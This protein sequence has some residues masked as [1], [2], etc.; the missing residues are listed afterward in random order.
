MQR[1]LAGILVGARWGVAGLVVAGSSWLALDTIFQLPQ[2][3]NVPFDLWYGNWLAVVVITG[4]FTV[5]LVGLL[6]PRR[7]A[8]WGEFGLCTAFLVSLFTEMFGVPLTIYL[9]APA[10]GL[11][12][13]GF[14][15]NESHL[16][17]FALARLRILPLAWGDYLVMVVSMAFLAVGAS[18]LAV[19]W[20]TVYRGR[21]VLMTD[22]IYRY[23]RHP[24]YLGLMLI[25][26]AFL[27]QWPTLPTLVMAP[28]LIVMYTRLARREDAELAERFGEAA[29]DY[30]LRTPAF[31]PGHR[32]RRAT[33]LP[34]T[35]VA[36][37]GR[38]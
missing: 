29:R 36:E 13:S 28:V 25:V 7:R 35:G 37:H 17:A 24:Q 21:A 8:E 33:T 20:A 9:L 5:F 2:S 1:S 30:A 4:A 10:L 32:A 14:G 31:L 15:L 27:I 22:G 23:H 18:L 3:E 26:V 12:A 19:G 34:R 38:Q 16:W 6:R 11:P